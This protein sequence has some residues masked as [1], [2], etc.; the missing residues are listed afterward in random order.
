MSKGTILAVCLLMVGCICVSPL[1]GKE[2]THVLLRRTAKQQEKDVRSEIDFSVLKGYLRQLPLREK[3]FIC[4]L[5]YKNTTRGA[6]IQK[7][8][9]YWLLLTQ[10]QSGPAAHKIADKPTDE[11]FSDFSALLAYLEK[12]PDEKKR[13]LFSW[14]LEDLYADYAQKLE[15][16]LKQSGGSEFLRSI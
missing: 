2:A 14:L 9:L 1:Q 13:S 8:G 11:I 7:E 4:F 3:N 6:N 10:E 5:L 12:L 16:R 15:A